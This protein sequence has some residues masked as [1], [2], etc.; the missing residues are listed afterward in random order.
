MITPT[1][2][3]IPHSEMDSIRSSVS[4]TE[5]DMMVIELYL[6]IDEAGFHDYGVFENIEW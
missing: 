3:T 6:A 2:Y 1:Q 5:P 4:E